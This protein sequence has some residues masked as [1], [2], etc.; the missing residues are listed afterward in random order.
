[1]LFD[2]VAQPYDVAAQV[3]EAFAAVSS[4]SIL[5]N[6]TDAL[7]ATQEKLTVSGALADL[8]DEGVNAGALRG[9]PHPCLS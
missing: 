5:A 9:R 8:G 1:M 3:N 4:G 2:A 7:D 6:F